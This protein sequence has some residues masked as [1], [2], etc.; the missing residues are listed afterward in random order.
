MLDTSSG[1]G[2]LKLWFVNMW[3]KLLSMSSDSTSEKRHSVD[4]LV[5]HSRLTFGFLVVNVGRL[6][7]CDWDDTI[8]VRLSLS[9]F[10]VSMDIVDVESA[11]TLSRFCLCILLP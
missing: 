5:F 2:I 8:S 9:W 10:A 11:S 4:D 6:C 7:E 3:I 1:N